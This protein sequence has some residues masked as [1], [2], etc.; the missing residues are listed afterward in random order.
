MLK[1]SDFMYVYDVKLFKF[2]KFDKGIDFIT[3]GLN[4]RTNMKFWQFY[5]SDE[6]NQA[7]AEWKQPK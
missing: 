5:R 1:Q 7:I 4:E 3:C 6:L 2:L